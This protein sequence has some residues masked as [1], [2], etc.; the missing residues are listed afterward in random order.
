MQARYEAPPSVDVSHAVIAMLQTDHG[1]SGI[2]RAA[3]R[4][5]M[6]LAAFSSV[7]ASAAAVLAIISYDAWFFELSQAITWVMQ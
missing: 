1:A 5:L 7:F 4:P 6:W 2:E 3:E